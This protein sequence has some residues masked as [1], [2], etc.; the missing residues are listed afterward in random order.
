MECL[1]RDGWT[2]ERHPDQPWPHDNCIGPGE[3]C[4]NPACPWWQG[5]KKPA[6]RRLIPFALDDD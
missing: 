5:P 2:C 4:P 6:L 1:C 3:Q